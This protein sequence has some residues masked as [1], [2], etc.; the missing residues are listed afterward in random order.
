MLQKNLNGK[1]RLLSQ[2]FY[3]L[4]RKK[5][6]NLFFDFDK[7]VNYKYVADRMKIK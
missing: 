2:E 3:V 7:K 5:T 1:D 6:I 4:I